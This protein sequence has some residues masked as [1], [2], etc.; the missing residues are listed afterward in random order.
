MFVSYGLYVC[1]NERII[2]KPAAKCDWSNHLRRLW[3]LPSWTLWQW[4]AI[5][6]IFGCELNEG[7]AKLRFWG[8]IFLYV[9]IRHPYWSIGDEKAETV[10]CLFWMIIYI[11]IRLYALVMY[12]VWMMIPNISFQ[13]AADFFFH[14][15]K[16][17][18][19]KNVVFIYIIFN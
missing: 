12:T 10:T 8:N 5:F 1:A 15:I 9:V 4:F 16:K 14:F 11:S 13:S 6:S 7:A 3:G 19:I 2:S 18:A 17:I